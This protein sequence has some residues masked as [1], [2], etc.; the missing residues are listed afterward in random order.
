MK[1]DI[2]RSARP[3]GAAIGQRIVIFACLASE[4]RDRAARRRQIF[5]KADALPEILRFGRN[6]IFRL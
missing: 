5:K 1:L 6:Y 2:R 4:C 3:S